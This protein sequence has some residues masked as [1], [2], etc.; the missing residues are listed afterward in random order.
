MNI[1]GVSAGMGPVNTET[2]ASGSTS[3]TKQTVN[4]KLQHG[5][6][7]N[8]GDTVGFNNPRGGMTTGTF[9][10]E[11]NGLGQLMDKLGQMHTQPMNF[12]MIVSSKDDEDEEE[13]TTIIMAGKPNGMF[14]NIN[15]AMNNMMMNDMA[16]QG[17]MGAIFGSNY[18]SEMYEQAS[19]QQG[20]SATLPMQVDQPYVG[21][22]ISGGY[23]SAA[24]AYGS[25]SS[26]ESGGAS[27]AG[28]SSGG[29][30]GGAAG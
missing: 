8:V 19:N 28:R 9:M 4:N 14:N 21:P 10:G 25:A 1:G 22:Q 16:S 17:M 6:S 11:D 2:V 29:A 26:G 13:S 7:I 18:A 27:A 24:S 23:G 15:N 30:G 3:E 5:G 12:L 20:P